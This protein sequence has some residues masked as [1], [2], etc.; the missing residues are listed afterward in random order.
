MYENFLKWVFSDLVLF[1]NFALVKLAIKQLKRFG[2]FKGSFRHQKGY[3]EIL[4]VLL[5]LVIFVGFCHL[6]FNDL[7]LLLV[8]ATDINPISFS[9]SFFQLC[10]A[11]NTNK[12]SFDQDSDPFT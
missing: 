12:L 1:N 10:R 2:K 9:V 5:Y 11:S 6:L 7:D 3:F 8:F 4:F